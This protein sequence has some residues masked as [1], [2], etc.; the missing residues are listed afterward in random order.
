MD[1]LRILVLAPAGLTTQPYYQLGMNAGFAVMFFY[2]VSGFLISTALEYKYP[3]TTNGTADFYQSRFVRIFS[4]YWP[5]VIVTLAALPAAREKFLSN[6]IADQ[7]TNIFLFGIEWRISFTETS[8]HWNAAV[9]G[10][11]QAWT[12]G[13]ELTFYCLAPFLLRSRTA[14]LSVFLLSVA[15]R[16]LCVYLV[17]FD[18]RWTYL[19]LPSTFLFFLIG[20]FARSAADRWPRMRA[21]AIGCAFFAASIAILVADTTSYVEWDSLRFWLA[22]LFF[23]MTLP[24][25]F[26]ATKDNAIFNLLGDLS[27]PV[28]LVHLLLIMVAINFG[29]F[30]ILPLSSPVVV[31]TTLA[32]TL[33]AAALAHWLLEKPTARLLRWGL[34]VVFTRPK[35]VRKTV[36]S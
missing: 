10:L 19:F 32:L 14:V 8:E 2:I 17:G 15:T 35:S 21:P 20:H 18:A 33:A 28:F 16:A 31:V 25:I 23:S 4:L 30:R 26:Q 5:M 6:S 9:Y 22:V 13:P 24:G 29:L 3:P 36:A 34:A 27:Y 1:H 7:F 11:Y 12:L